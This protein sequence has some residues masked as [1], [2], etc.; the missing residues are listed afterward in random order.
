MS[1]R[2]LRSSCAV[3]DAGRGMLDTWTASQQC[4]PM[5]E[6]SC[7]K[8]QSQITSQIAEGSSSV[9]AVSFSTEGF[10]ALLGP[11][12]AD[13][14]LLIAHDTDARDNMEKTSPLPPHQILW[15]ESYPNSYATA[16]WGFFTD[17]P[18]E[19]VASGCF[20]TEF[21]G[22]LEMDDKNGGLIMR[23]DYCANT[24]QRGEFW[25]K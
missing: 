5:W 21:S 25:L 12:F 19:A 7:F 13:G 1:T 23:G 6:L 24:G 10:D 16:G 2:I 17:C 9:I 4:V 8:S 14:V 18:Y 22:R 11:T 20:S 15:R 3:F